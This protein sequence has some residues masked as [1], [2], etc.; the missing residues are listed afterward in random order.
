[1]K[2]SLLKK[3]ISF[4]ISSLLIISC[5]YNR[6]SSPFNQ[7]FGCTQE[8][9]AIIDSLYNGNFEPVTAYLEK[10]GDPLL[11]CPH[12]PPYELSSWRN[13]SIH[14]GILLF[15]TE[16]LV[17]YYLTLEITQDIKNHYLNHY[18][19]LRNAKMT[20]YLIEQD[21]H[22]YLIGCCPF[23]LESITFAIDNGYDLN[24]QDPSNGYSLFLEFAGCPS[25][26]DAGGNIEVMK[27]LISKGA[28]INVLTKKGQTALD[29]AENDKIIE[30][31]KELYQ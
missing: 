27:Y 18:V 6:S 8:E 14:Q 7:G 31:L 11:E 20:K 30:F 19:V 12:A 25:D 1:M 13:I 29:I 16:E 3:G 28:D 26:E 10:G 4:F 23:C 15:G 17:K 24:W 9:R 5:S 22:L 2:C 21:A